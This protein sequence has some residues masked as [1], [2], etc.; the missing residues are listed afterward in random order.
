MKQIIFYITIFS[1]LVSCAVDTSEK[2]EKHLAIAKK[3]MDAVEKKNITMMD[4][5]LADNYIG[6]GPSVADSVNK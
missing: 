2:E 3:Y 6:F 5:L 1:C 4:S